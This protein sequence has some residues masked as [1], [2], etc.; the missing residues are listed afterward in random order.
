MQLVRTSVGSGR[1]FW[2][3][4]AVAV[5]AGALLG[6]LGSSG[7]VGAAKV[8]GQIVAGPIAATLNYATVRA[9]VSQGGVVVF[10]NFDV[11]LHNVVSVDGLFS[12]PLIGAGKTVKVSGVASLPVGAYQFVCT[13]HS[14]M[15][16]QILVRKL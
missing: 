8:Q 13:L 1:S 5:A 2:E 10:R 12:T 3:R 6:A 7:S 9:V 4:L 11:P 16:G 15:K 14:K